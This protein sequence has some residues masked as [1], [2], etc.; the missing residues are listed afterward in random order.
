MGIGKNKDTLYII[1]FGLSKR[2]RDM[3]TG[4]HI[5]FRKGKSLVGT[6]RFASLNT[7]YGYEQSRRD[8]LES[9][10]FVLIYLLKGSLPWQGIQ[11]KVKKEKYEKILKLKENTPIKDLCNKL[12][13]EFENFVNYVRSLKFDKAPD[14]SY[15]KGL[16]TKIILD[17]K[18]TLD[19]EF[20]WISRK[21]EVRY[22]INQ[23]KSKKNEEKQTE[24]N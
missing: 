21:E 10:F 4:R 16:V 13:I 15:L 22:L 19:N 8:D 17:Q 1:D 2:Y 5:P 9:L 11:A 20:S 18:F 6:A 14:Y 7:H 23:G 12:P 24:G 3:K